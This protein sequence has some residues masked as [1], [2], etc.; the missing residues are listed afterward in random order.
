[1]NS[2]CRN[3][4]E[5]DLVTDAPDGRGHTGTD[6]PWKT[7]INLEQSGS[8]MVET[9]GITRRHGGR[10]AGMKQSGFK[11]GKGRRI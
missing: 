3:K 10:E 4:I 5:I 11:G 2:L 8:V 1:L 6:Q 9:P 7:V